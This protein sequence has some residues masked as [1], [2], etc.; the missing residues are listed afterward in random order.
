MIMLFKQF[1]HNLFSIVNSNPKGL[2]PFS[3]SQFIKLPQSHG[4]TFIISRID[5]KIIEAKVSKAANTPTLPIL[6]AMTSSFFYK[7]VAS[8]DTASLSEIIPAAVF[9]PTDVT[10]AVPKP[11]SQRDFARIIPPTPS[12]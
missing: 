2:H 4:R 6:L 9:K 10:I 5:L 8:L 3:A 12:F 7:S 1:Y 11:A